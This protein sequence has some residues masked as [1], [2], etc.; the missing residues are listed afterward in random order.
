MPSIERTRGFSAAMAT[1][2]NA[3]PFASPFT[4]GTAAR[5]A[6]PSADLQGTL[7]DTFHRP[8][9][10]AT[11]EDRRQLL[12]VDVAA[13]DDAHDLRCAGVSRKR[14]GDGSR[15]RAFGD[16]PVPLDQELHRRRRLRQ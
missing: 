16:D 10:H 6:I 7:I 8:L 14:R 9:G 13:A 2:S 5:S 1:S 11:L 12:G 3:N 15:A 4:Y